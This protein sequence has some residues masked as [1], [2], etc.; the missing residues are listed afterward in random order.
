MML[1][2]FLS[3]VALLVSTVGM[4][5]THFMDG[6]EESKSTTAMVGGIMLMVAGGSDRLPLTLSLDDTLSIMW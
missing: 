2:I 6:N 5:C 1:S 4:K 3:A